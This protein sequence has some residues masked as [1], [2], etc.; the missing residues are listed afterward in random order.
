MILGLIFIIKSNNE[1]NTI[2]KSELNKKS[3]DYVPTSELIKRT[4]KRIASSK[5][6]LAKISA[7]EGNETILD[8]TDSESETVIC[9]EYEVTGVHISSRKN[10][11]INYC[12]EYDEI[13]LEHEKYNKFSNRAIV[14]K[15][16]GKKIGYIAKYDVEEVQGIIKKPFT[17]HISK[18]DY[19]GS[20]L[21]V[22]I[23]L[24]N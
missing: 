14:V 17:S 15:H 12:T 20:Y 6:L 9:K 11:I 18:I 13:E 22:R 5:A 24:E 21:T 16:E 3:D 1:S 4:E 23:E 7:N 19:D 10:Y 8:N 2:S